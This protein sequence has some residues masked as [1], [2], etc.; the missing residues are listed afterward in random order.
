M[1]SFF[2]KKIILVIGLG[3]SG[4]SCAKALLQKG[5][6]VGGWDDNP[7]ARLKGVEEGVHVFPNLEGIPW[8]C[9]DHVVIGP[10]VPHCYP[11]P[12][13]AVALGLSYGLHPINDIE[14]FFKDRPNATIVGV[15]G[16]NGKSTTAH[17]IAHLLRCEE[18]TVFI[19][20]NNGTPVGDL[21]VTNLP[22]D[23]SAGG[24]VFY[25]LELSSYQLELAPSLKLDIGVLLNIA[26]HHLERYR[27]FNHYINT[28]KHVFSPQECQKIIGVDDVWCQSLLGSFGVEN[29]VWAV[30]GAQDTGEKSLSFLHTNLQDKMNPQHQ[31]TSVL[32][33]PPGVHRQS[34][35]ASFAVGRLLGLSV[36]GMI[37]GLSSFC[38]LSY[39]QQQ[40]QC[41]CGICYVND[42]KATN[43]H[44]VASAFQAYGSCPPIYW[45]GGGKKQHL[46]LDAL[47]NLFSFCSL[48][49]H[50]FLVGESA[51]E[52]EGILLRK[53]VS[54]EKSYTLAK[55]CEA[56]THL[57]NQKNP[58]NPQ[59]QIIDP[60]DIKSRRA[61]RGAQQG[62]CKGKQKHTQGDAFKESWI[63]PPKGVVLFSP[64]FPSF[65]QFKNFEERGKAFDTWVAQHQ[66]THQNTPRN[67]PRYKDK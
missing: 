36:K 23:L 9:L 60:K 42:S 48:I 67:H 61:Q 44:A 25:V 43:F 17:L 1:T 3:V 27:D 56:A 14:C 64:G 29:N 41:A 30:S 59:T 31:S 16:T 26:P 2:D 28:K 4:M 57:C 5:A 18:K 65:D 38:A 39:R 15:T 35:A 40:T 66:K 12:C 52:M 50:A 34:I 10:G 58:K 33:P 53:G 46:S 45:I 6:I 49:D 55:A 11:T 8:S 20:G 37:R 21:P 19:G 54:C 24:G 51:D 13:G 47:E 62:T 32:C 63:T 7:K 22:G